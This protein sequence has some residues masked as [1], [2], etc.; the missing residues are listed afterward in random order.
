M[1]L[2]GIDESHKILAAPDMP[3]C[4]QLVVIYRCRTSPICMT[5]SLVARRQNTMLL[6]LVP[7]CFSAHDS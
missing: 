5:Y 7:L 1:S 2:D 4:G 3:K 6:S